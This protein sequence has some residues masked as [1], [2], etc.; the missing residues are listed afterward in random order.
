MAVSALWSLDWGCAQ[1]APVVEYLPESKAFAMN[2]AVVYEA[3]HWVVL[4]LS[5][6]RT[7]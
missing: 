5:Y 4:E 2:L 1:M 3:E 7:D 6:K